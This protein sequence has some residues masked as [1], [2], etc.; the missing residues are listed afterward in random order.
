V[1]LPEV[2][3][4]R[5]HIAL[6]VAGDSMMPWLRPGDVILV[7]TQ[8]RVARDSLV[9]AR[10]GEHGYVVKHVTRCGRAELELSSFNRAYAPFV[11]ERSPGSVIGVVVARLERDG[12]G[13]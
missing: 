13:S 10:H 12:G 6:N 11:I 4:G 8:G 1:E 5:E 2:A 9:V 7:N 3:K